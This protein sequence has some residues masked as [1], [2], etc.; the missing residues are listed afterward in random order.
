MPQ[1]NDDNEGKLIKRLLKEYQSRIPD[2]VN[3]VDLLGANENAHTR[4]LAA[5]LGFKREGQMP[6]VSSFIERFIR[7]EEDKECIQVQQPCVETQLTY[8]DALIWEPSKYAIIIENKINW[9]VDQHRQL[10]GY[11]KTTKGVCCIEP[12]RQCYVIYLTD[13]GRKEVSDISLTDE[14]KQLLDYKNDESPGRYIKLN[15]REDIL[16]WL[17]EEVLAS[18]RYIEQMLTSMLQQYIDYLEHRFALKGH[19][20]EVRFLEAHLQGNE[21]EKYAQLTQ[22]KSFCEAFPGEKEL[23]KETVESFAS[24]VR[25][26]MEQMVKRNYSLNRQNAFESKVSTIINWARENGFTPHK[27]KN[28]IFFEFRI[29][30][31]GERIKFQINIDLTGDEVKVVL[32]NN[33]FKDDRPSK[34][35][36]DF[37]VLWALFKRKFPKRIESLVNYEAALLDT[38]T[39]ESQLLSMLNDSVK[40]FLDAFYAEFRSKNATNS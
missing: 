35:L 30:P 17:K 16:P 7:N 1:A 22:W 27:W 25:N 29:R 9:A 38:F 37:P 19:N 31:Y 34:A 39:S 28:C 32:F 33:D 36:S 10:E 21:E 11:I 5:I 20:E 15:Y 3:L 23:P 8:I 40:E 24:Q 2:R 26:A 12:N 13:D 6:F 18:C 4:I 14:A